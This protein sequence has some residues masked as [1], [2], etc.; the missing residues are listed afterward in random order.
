M[1]EISHTD[2][3]LFDILHSNRVKANEV[4]NQ[5][6]F[7]GVKPN[8][9]D[10]YAETAHF[11]YELLQ[12][13]DDANATE[14]TII[15]KADRLLFKHNG[16]KHFDITAEDDERVGDI[17]SITGIGNSSKENTQNKIG[18]FGVGFKAVF[19]YTDTPEIF[20]DPFKFKIEDLIVPTLIEYDYPERQ[21]GETLFVLPFRNPQKSF[22]EIKDRLETL[23]NPI[24]F[25]RHLKKIVWHIDTGNRHNT[26]TEYSKTLLERHTHNGIKLEKYHLKNAARED[27]MFLFSRDITIP[28]VDGNNTIL[29]ICIG[30]YYD[31]QNKS[32]ITKNTQ[33]I[34]CFF[35]TKETFKTCFI[36]HAPFLLTENRQNIKRNENLNKYLLRC[37]ASLAADAVATLRDYGQKNG[38]LLINE[39]I[40][41]IIPLYELRCYYG[42]EDMFEEPMKEAFNKMLKYK[43]VL[44]SRNNKYLM[45]E[46]SYTTTKAVFDLLTQ[47]QFYVLCGN[48]RDKDEDNGSPKA[49]SLADWDL[50]MKSKMMSKN[51]DFLKWELIMRLSKID[52]EN[53]IYGNIKD[54][55]I[56]DFGNDISADFMKAQKVDWVTKFYTFLRNDAPKYW[57]N[58]PQTRSTMHVFRS[59]PIIKIQN[60]E[61]VAPFI[62]TT[63]PNVFLPIENNPNSHSDYNFISKEYLKEDMARK[64]F[65]E[66]EIKQ[67]EEN[68]YIRN[69][70]LK[71]YEEDEVDIDDNVLKSDFQLLLSYYKK[72]RDTGAEDDYICLLRDK[73]FLVGTDNTLY[74]ASSLYIKTD[75]LTAYFGDNAVFFNTNF[76]KYIIREFKETF[77]NEFIRKLGALTLPTIKEDKY[78]YQYSLPTRFRK[79]VDAMSFYEF[80]YITD[81][82]L[83][84]FDDAYTKGRI[85]EY[86]SAKLWNEV[87]PL[88]K[89]TESAKIITRQK[90]RQY[91][92][93]NYAES[94]FI[95]LLK[96]RKWLYDC[97]GNAKAPDDLFLEDLSS[98]YDTY[99]GIAEWLGIS[100]RTA[101]LREKYNATDEEQ[102]NF[103]LGADIRQRFPG[104]S[105]EEIIALLDIA[106]SIDRQEKAQ[107]EAARRRKDEETQQREQSLFNEEQP[108]TQPESIEDKMKKRWD[109]K[110]NRHIGK[111]HSSTANQGEIPFDNSP[112]IDAPDN[113]APF[114]AQPSAIPQNP[115]VE[116]TACAEK[117]LKAKDTTAQTQA[118]NAKDM[119]DILDLLKQT[120]EYTFKWFKVLMELMHAGQDKITERRVQIDFSRYE[121]ICSDKVLHLIEP[122]QPV[123][124]WVCDAEKY[125][126]TALADGK[127]A[128]I[129]GLIVKT[130]DD[131]IDIS[132]EVNNKMLAD[133][134]RA[135]KI[136]IIAIDN[137]NIINS[138]ETRFLQLEKEDDFD[139][140]AN[141]PSNLEFIYGPPGTGKTTRLVARVHE[142]LE[143][144]PNAKILVLTPTNKA[145]DVVAIKMSNDDVCE[146]GLARYGATESLYLI[147]EIGCVTNRD[148][149]DM[150]WHNIVVATAA[151]YAYDYLQPDDTAICDYPWDYIFIDE[152]SM[153]DILTITYILYKGANA[154]QIIISGDPKQIQPVVQNDMP[155]YNIYNMV[156]LQGFANAILDYTRY[157]VEGL[158]MQHRSI[159]VIGNLVSQFAYDGLVDCDPNR[160]PMK[161]LTLDSIAIKNVNF[162]GFDV[163]ELDEIRGLNEVNKSAF[164]LYSVIFTYNMVEYTIKQIEKHHP[165]QDYTIG[166]VCAYRAQSDAIKNMFENRPLDSAF[167][168]VTCGT[169][170]SFQGDE[171]DIMFIVLNPPAMCTSGTHVNN[172][173]I[174]N[175]AMSRARDY[176]FFIMPNG[177]PKGFYM[178][179]R[180]GAVVPFTDRTILNC[181]DIEKVM[182][183]GNDNFIYENTHVTCHMPVNVYCEDNALYEVRM[184]D[185]ALDL[186]LNYK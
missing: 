151:R 55:T 170:H 108:T 43:A 71:K 155:A 134:Q 37:L 16:T 38:T 182:F 183:H 54:Y 164:N 129:D 145:A 97:E 28:L 5:R 11:V 163:T 128:K 143:K 14:V 15:L 158:M 79:I 159:P 184:S 146:S 176:I 83:F 9:V 40:V 30:F 139:M 91:S 132:V 100:K 174:I 121:M 147:E 48:S 144:E 135:K 101:D 56:E 46:Q 32:L 173:N 130:S 47:E 7:R 116:D 62:N 172:E 102:S 76:Y 82:F 60:G 96:K 148:T 107:A 1:S 21:P 125:S 133:L 89:E 93:V 124:A 69:I 162:V 36:S 123:P 63:T 84:C 118:E 68:D 131:S 39:N 104:K 61:W 168:R 185:N 8:V 80:N 53:R 126:I 34:Y 142:L 122:T 105:D 154:K 94:T 165:N 161:P 127:T 99:N 65:N 73:L 181:R 78:N 157:P 12:N 160:T 64:F 23:K 66:L 175:V 86:V 10:K 49:N 42:E 153:I 120:P 74:R 85:T 92:N 75:F 114:F 31:E 45:V 141:L 6:D 136:R 4:F 51:I 137:T 166:V 50:T 111:P 3:Q 52:D 106:E 110:K 156:G 27:Y 41:D 90:R 177:Q 180:I 117:N 26:T 24:L 179:H 171:C 25:L 70:I 59:A 152:A 87:I 19:Q 138:L 67:P 22:N 33:N 178:K 29:P 112:G 113:N 119:V 103:A 2:Q 169:V 140:N 35:P 186:K 57:K 150:S 58:T 44:L 18:K 88:Y 95:H 98:E 13:A 115:D 20:D 149:T 109:E 17:N 77:V 167:C 72:V 81:Y